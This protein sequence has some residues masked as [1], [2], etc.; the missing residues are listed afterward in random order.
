ME[1]HDGERVLEGKR[2]A[3]EGAEVGEEEGVCEKEDV[4]DEV[5]TE[6]VEEFLR[7]AEA[8]STSESQKEV[9]RPRLAI[10]SHEDIR[11]A[12]TSMENQWLRSVQRQRELDELKKRSE[13][14]LQRAIQG[15]KEAEREKQEAEQEKKRVFCQW[16]REKKGGKNYGC[17]NCRVL[18]V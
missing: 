3:D 8:Q 5:I 1:A 16:I 9:K 11:R 17:G 15:F 13:E 10:S 14:R 18:C 2:M 6:D 7:D 12:L 4:G